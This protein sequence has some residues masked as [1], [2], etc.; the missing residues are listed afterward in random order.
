MFRF[1]NAWT[2]PVFLFGTVMLP[3]GV[4]YPVQLYALILKRISPKSGRLQK[5]P[6]SINNPQWMDQLTRL[7]MT[8]TVKTRDQV[9]NLDSNAK[10]RVGLGIL[11]L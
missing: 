8:G 9:D 1:E 3:P 5:C 7:F 4:F 2:I 11:H 10:D 6:R